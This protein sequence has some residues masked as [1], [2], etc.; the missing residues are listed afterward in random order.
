MMRVAFVVEKFP[1]ISETF[2]LDE[3]VGAIRR[4]V[5]VDVYALR[6]GET[7]DI[8]PAYLMNSVRALVMGFRPSGAARRGSSQR[9]QRRSRCSGAIPPRSSRAH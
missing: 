3:I 9:C 7:A 5:E 8:H 6:K 1:N 2:I 4:G